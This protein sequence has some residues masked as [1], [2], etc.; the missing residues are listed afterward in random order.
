MKTLKFRYHLEITF[1]SP[2]T[3]HSFTI[4]CVPETD[5]RQK[6][7]HHEVKILPKEFLNTGRDSF[8][9]PYF[10]GRAES[11]HDLFEVEENGLVQT[12][13]SESTKVGRKH[14]L[15]IFLAQSKYTMPDDALKSFYQALKIPKQ[16]ANLDKALYIM[17]ALREQLSYVPGVTGISTTAAQA[18]TKKQ[19]VCQDYSHI[20]LSLCRLSGIPC[21]YVAGMLIGEGKSHAWIEAE[22]GGRWYGLDPT[23]GVRVLEDHIKIAHGRDYEDCP[24]NRGVFTG[25]A[26]QTQNVTVSVEPE[27]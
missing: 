5:E 18:W 8:G 1:D 24:M 26:A 6:V 16:A 9:N 7:L 22:D 15:G 11:P 13:L 17:D 27:G 10:F 19:G 25:M 21:R 2:V 12:G 23:N 3:Q 14:R 20:M 4:R